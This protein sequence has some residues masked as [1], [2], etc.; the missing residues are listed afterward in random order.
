[1]ARP[2]HKRLL[3]R[4]AHLLATRWHPLLHAVAYVWRR[5][6]F[7]TTVVAITGSLGKTTAKECLG[8]ILASRAV[9]FKTY[10]NQNDPIYG[11]A[12]NILRLR[13]WHR[14]AVLE[15]ATGGPGQ[16]WGAARLVAPDVAL[17][18]R[19]AP[20]HLQEF[21][22]VDEIATEKAELLRA[23]GPGKLA[24]LN[25]DDPRVA[26]MQPPNG[27]RVIRFGTSPEADVRAEE[28][29]A[30][31][32]GRLRFRVRSGLAAEEVRTQLVGEHWLPSVLGA[33]A[34]AEVLGVSLGEAARALGRVAPFPA[35]CQ[36]VK[37][38]NGAV[39]LRD[40]YSASI[41]GFHAAM[42]V[43]ERASA[44]RR[45]VVL[46]DVSDLAVNSKRRR[47]LVV[48]EAARVCEALVLIGQSADWGA[49]RAADAGMTPDAARGF[50]EPQA[51]AEFL[52]SDLRAGD[53]VLVKG[54]TSDHVG[55]V[56]LAQLGEVR[57]WS[58]PCPKHS[59]CDVCW[60]LGL[61]KEQLAQI[62]V[63]DP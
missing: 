49:R 8:A 36:P 60:E 56:F 57:C 62:E 1:M 61:T 41:E 9:T 21:R 47:R 39:V 46:S 10:R 34:A 4:V 59:L 22:D 52:K 23:L 25:Q 6:L 33:I 63:V 3:L 18:L 15:V 19:V 58:F 29:T 11:V 27:V 16:L 35:R 13:P 48:S 45:L 50:D 2:I 51:A 14:Y 17:I 24:V 30:A 42:R 20:T 12:R 54:R 44:K 7:R 28:V 38:P 55:R 37:L 26:G 32:P 40:D 5:L 53:L 43:M 31:W